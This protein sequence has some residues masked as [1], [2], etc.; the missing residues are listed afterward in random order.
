M[1][2]THATADFCLTIDF[3]KGQ[4]NPSR[5][6]RAMSDL[7]DAFQSIDETLIHSVHSKIEPV[8]LLEDVEVSSIK[9]WLRQAIDSIDDEALKDVDYKKA[10]GAYLLKA[11]KALIYFLEDKTT[12]TS[13]DLEVIEGELVELAAET[14][15]LHLPSYEPV[16]RRALLD[17]LQ[18]VNKALE[19]LEDG[20]HATIG[21]GGETASFNMTL[22]LAPETIDELSISETKR[23]T[24]EMIMKVKRP[25]FIGDSMWQFHFDGR[26][27]DVKIADT[28]WLSSFQQGSTLV[29][30]G[31]AIRAQVAITVEYGHER[32]VIKI[33]YD[34]LEVFEVIQRVKSRQERMLDGDSGISVNR[35]GA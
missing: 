25:D 20:D 6:F 21:S 26:A 33:H 30:P 22:S 23:H 9:A 16:S 3:K 7:I 8:L 1:A 34:A 14:D 13:G 15:V 11:K 10:I 2:T 4:G 12:I 24:Q 28:R 31:D 35:R 19:P 32:D 5:A 29:L 27:I 17:G 18:Q